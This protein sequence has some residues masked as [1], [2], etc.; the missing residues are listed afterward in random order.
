MVLNWFI[1]SDDAKLFDFG[2]GHPDGTRAVLEVHSHEVPFLLDD[3]QL[4]G[5]LNYERMAAAPSRLYGDGLGSHYAR[6]DLTL[7]K[8][9]A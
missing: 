3:G 1:S 9:F 8:H 2:F 4:V 7:S 6:Q 5:H